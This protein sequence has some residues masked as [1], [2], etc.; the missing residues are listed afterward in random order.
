MGEHEDQKWARLQRE[1]AQHQ[2]GEPR[3]LHPGN[4]GHDEERS[5]SQEQ[6]WAAQTVSGAPPGPRA[7]QAAE[8]GEAPATPRADPGER[9]VRGGEAKKH[10]RPRE[11]TTPEPGRGAH[12][13]EPRAAREPLTE[14]EV[15][16]RAPSEGEEPT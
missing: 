12:R 4:E 11:E 3:L 14:A 6:G 16:T 7:A 10:P 2:P 9:H 15:P 13:L 5:R 8:V 1:R